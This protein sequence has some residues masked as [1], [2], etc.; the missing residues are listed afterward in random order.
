MPARIGPLL[1]EPSAGGDQRLR[2]LDRVHHRADHA[3]GA[4]VQHLADDPRL[5]PGHAH[6][7]QHRVRLHGLEARD[8]GEVVLHPMLE[9]HGHA[10][11]AGLRHDLGG[12]AVR[13]GEPAV[14]GGLVLLPA[15]LELVRHLLP[16]GPGRRTLGAGR[17]SVNSRQVR[18]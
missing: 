8:H 13:D 18:E 14:D 9:V 2:L 10:V 6:H 4:A 12:E 16:S 11:P 7:R 15:L 5:V 3:V 1:R 17:Q